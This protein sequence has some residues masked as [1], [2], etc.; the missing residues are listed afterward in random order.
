MLALSG[1]VARA[2]YSP[3]TGA[4]PIW[5]MPPPAWLML[6]LAISNSLPA[7]Y[8]EGL[9]LRGPR[10]SRP[11]LRTPAQLPSG[12]SLP[13][14]AS[15]AN[16]RDLVIA[17]QG[18]VSVIGHS[19]KSITVKGQVE[20]DSLSGPAFVVG[21]AQARWR[22]HKRW[23]RGRSI[24]GIDHSRIDSGHEPPFLPIRPCPPNS[25]RAKRVQPRTCQLPAAGMQLPR[26]LRHVCVENLTI[27]G[28]D[29]E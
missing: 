5:V 24:P 23:F 7:A 12:V 28:V 10:P 15:M 20:R 3:C 22:H 14:P 9:P 26:N 11:G 6:K 27:R 16:I 18:H 19:P 25:S 21:A 1:P 2:R 29:V 17:F 4:E 8:K 13:V